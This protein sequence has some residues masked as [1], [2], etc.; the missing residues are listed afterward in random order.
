MP[1]HRQDGTQQMAAAKL[2]DGD[3]LTAGI[4]AHPA[5]GFAAPTLR[6]EV[7]LDA[8]STEVLTVVHQTMEPITVSLW[9]RPSAASSSASNRAGSS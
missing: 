8:L 4:T 1:A 5:S 9:L 3:W 6:D 2:P 7:D